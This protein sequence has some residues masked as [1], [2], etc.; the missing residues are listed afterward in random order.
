MP[1]PVA[2]HM[3]GPGLHSRG[4][5]S[6]EL[7]LAI[8]LAT[9]VILLSLLMAMIGLPRL[10]KGLQLPSEPVGQQEEDRARHAAAITAIA[11]IGKAQQQLL[12]GTAA[13]ADIH[14]HVAARVIAPCQHRPDRDASSEGEAPQL[15]KADQVEA[16]LRMAALQAERDNIFDQARHARIS[17][18]TSRRL[19][20]E[21][22]LAEARHRQ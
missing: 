21:L 2:D 10:L 22:D 16:A 13:D 20:R 17:D 18:E 19:V 11:A 14:P 4:M 15:R 5:D 7:V 6:I 12:N 3:A 1:V 9:A 8:F